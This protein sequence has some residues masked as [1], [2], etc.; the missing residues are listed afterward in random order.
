VES[1]ELVV[2]SS[3]EALEVSKAAQGGVH[4]IEHNEN[5]G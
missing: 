2:C 4:K 1:K 5:T 3:K